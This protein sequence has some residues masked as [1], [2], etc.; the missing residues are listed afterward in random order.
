MDDDPQTDTSQFG[1]AAPLMDPIAKA[2]DRVRSVFKYIPG[3]SAPPVDTS[4]HD[5]KVAEANK[6]FADDQKTPPA[7]PNLKPAPRKR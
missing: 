4:W 6:S 2:Y 3:K 5:Q 7:K 1:A